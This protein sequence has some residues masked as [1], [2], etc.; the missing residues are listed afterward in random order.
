MAP[1]NK[2]NEWFIGEGFICINKHAEVAPKV[3]ALDPLGP[4]R[5]RMELILIIYILGD[6]D[7]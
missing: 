7:L 1:A 4:A 5:P 3:D 6:N 2:I